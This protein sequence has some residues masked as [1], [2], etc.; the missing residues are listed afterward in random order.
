MSKA[1][2]KTIKLL[3]YEGDLSGVIKLE[4]ASWTYSGILYSA[5]R[6]SVEKLFS[7]D[8]CKRFG[9]YLLISQNRVYVG[10]SSDLSKRISQHLTGKDWWTSVVILTSSSDKLTATGID[11]LEAT[12]IEKSSCIKSLDCDNKNKGNPINVGDFEKVELD[13]YLEDALFYMELIGITIFN[14]NATHSNVLINAMDIATRLSLGKR[15]RTAAIDYLRQKKVKLP[16]NKDINY[17]SK[18]P[19][20]KE[21]WINP[22]IKQLEKEWTLILN[23]TITRELL[24]LRIPAK[25][26]H[27]QD[28]T[29]K[30]LF[31]RTDKPNLVSIKLDLETLVDKQS[32]TDF[33]PFV[34]E[35]VSY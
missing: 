19:D 33:S 9:V 5:P 26:I 20:K 2:A 3:L 10:Q 1:K 21:Y 22:S 4:D 28:S 34:E 30:G 8:A 27:L 31:V 7:T 25:T 15:E 32:S 23:N 29:G 17:A 35:R 16:T 11:Y 14:E 6:D 12:L 24:V 13:Q 18:Q